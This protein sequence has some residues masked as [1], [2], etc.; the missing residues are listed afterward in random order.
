MIKFQ[1]FWSACFSI[2]RS[3]GQAL[4]QY[5]GTCLRLQR[6]LGILGRSNWCPS[7]TI[8]W[9]YGKI[10]IDWPVT[11]K[12]IA[13]LNM[14]YFICTWVYHI[15]MCRIVFYCAGF[16]IYV[17]FLSWYHMPCICNSLEPESVILHGMCYILAW[18]LCILHGICYIWPCLPSILHGIC[19]VLALQPLICMVFATFW[20][21]KRSCEFLEIFFR[22]SFRDSFRVSLGFHLGFHVGFHLGFL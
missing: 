11:G 4:V 9:L 19:H 6:R 10:S 21:F 22:V 5:F 1:S 8:L 2:R 3:S 7:N 16:G 18:S 13:V 20:Y 12:K 17:G 14:R 15:R